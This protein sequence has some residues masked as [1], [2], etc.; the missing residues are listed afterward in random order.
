MNEHDTPVRRRRLLDAGQHQPLLDAYGRHLAGTGLSPV[1]VHIHLGSALHFL[2]WLIQS[3]IA[4]DHVGPDIVARFAAH[5]CRCHSSPRRVGQYYINRVDRFVR[6]LAERG[7]LPSRPAPETPA[8]DRNVADWLDAQARQRGLS[9]ITIVRHGRMLAQILPL[10]GADPSRYTARI[11]RDG[12][13]DHA[14][15][16]RSA[17]YPKMVASALRLYLRHL[18]HRGLAA[19]DLDRAVPVAKTWRLA[20]LPRYLE[21]EAV[22]RL[23]ATCD[24][25]TPG[26]RRDRA[27]LSLLARLGLRARDVAELRLADIDWRAATL[28]VCGK[29]QREVR[30]PLPQDAGDAL[31]AWLTGP[32]AAASCDTV[33]MQLLPPFGPVSSGVVGGVVRR[34]IER[35]GIENAPSRG[36]HLL[37]HSAATAMLRGGATLDAIATVLRHRS[38]DTTA[39]YAKVD[40]AMLDAVAQAWPPHEAINAAPPL[41]PALGLAWP[42]GATC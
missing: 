32:R 16:A 37:R 18:A 9:P 36:S 26:G 28:R 15:T 31:I 22:E 30:L 13:L 8:V 24:P 42:E 21:P 23:M 19:P 6:H 12:L 29:G 38:T 17:H 3:G 20:S 5:E 33:F 34:G 39:H 35:A 11:I 1:S 2:A 10:I 14:R 41:A 40:V 25:Q 27:I 4:L 7:V